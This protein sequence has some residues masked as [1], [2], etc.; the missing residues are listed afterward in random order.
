[1][2]ETWLILFLIL[3]IRNKFIENLERNNCYLY[4]QY[5]MSLI[6]KHWSIIIPVFMLILY[7]IFEILILNK[8]YAFLPY[9]KLYKQ[10][11]LFSYFGLV[12]KY[13]LC[14]SM[15]QKYR[16]KELISFVTS[17][18]ILSILCLSIGYLLNYIAIQANFGHM[19]VF[20]SCTYSTGYTD[21]NSFTKDTFYIL[22]DNNSKLI[23]LCDIYDIYIS[24]I[25]IGDMFVRMNIFIILLFSIK[26]S[27]EIQK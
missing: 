17:P 26:K 6:F 19:P 24:N 10:I 2:I 4:K 8:Y 27:N 14:I 5:D 22:G 15:Y 18:F 23:P 11:T 12:Y 7:I 1:M 21:I 25:S 20:P 3:F 13:D 9:C 16:D